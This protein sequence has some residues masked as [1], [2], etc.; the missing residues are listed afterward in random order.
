ME[1]LDDVLPQAQPLGQSAQILVLAQ[2]SYRRFLRTHNVSR[3]AIFLSRLCTVL[4][5]SQRAIA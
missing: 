4:C 2:A 3:R 1:S 5:P